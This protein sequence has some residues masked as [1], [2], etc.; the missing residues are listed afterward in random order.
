MSIAFLIYLLYIYAISSLMR[1][2]CVYFWNIWAYVY[3]K[4][5]C[6]SYP[7]AFAYKVVS[8]VSAL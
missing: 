2:Y 6:T 5:S 4:I 3:E 8:E 7:I 1:K